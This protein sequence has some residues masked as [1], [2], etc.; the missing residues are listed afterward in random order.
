LSTV[1]CRVIFA[2]RNTERE[3]LKPD[4]NT[5]YPYLGAFFAEY[6][7]KPGFAGVP[8]RQAKNPMLCMD[9]LLAATASRPFNPLRTNRKSPFGATLSRKDRRALR[10]PRCPRSS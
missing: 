1:F 5:S 3:T 6:R 2:N 7:K 9:F 4:K 10:G 8:S